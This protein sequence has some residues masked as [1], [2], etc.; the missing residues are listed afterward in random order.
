M[1]GCK[2]QI[3]G[4]KE[5]GFW[6]GNLGFGGAIHR[7]TEQEEKQV[8]GRLRKWTQRRMDCYQDSMVFQKL[9]WGECFRKEE[10]VST[11]TRKVR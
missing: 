6:F 9:R 1:R 5:V 8:W 2:E 10:V 7:D 3:G 11:A 4:A